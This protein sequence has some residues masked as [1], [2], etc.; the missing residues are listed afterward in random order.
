VE[1]FSGSAKKEIYTKSQS[2][3][4]IV[5]VL[6]LNHRNIAWGGSKDYLFFLHEGEINDDLLISD[7]LC[8]HTL[9]AGVD[10]LWNF[11]RRLDLLE[12]MIPV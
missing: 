1:N 2:I 6:R 7:F 4:C 8:V 11:S 3:S 10:L 12:T 9:A 5:R